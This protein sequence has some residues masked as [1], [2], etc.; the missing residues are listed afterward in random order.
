MRRMLPLGSRR[1][2]SAEAVGP[3]ERYMALVGSKALIYD[4]HQYR[5][6]QKLDSFRHD[7]LQKPLTYMDRRLPQKQDQGFFSSWFTQSPPPAPMP[8]RKGFYLYGSPGTGKT[9]L[10]DTL[11]ETLDI[12]KKKRVHFNSFML[13][14]HE[15]LHL[16]NDAGGDALV[17]VARELSKEALLICFDEFQVTDIADAMILKRLFTCLF[18]H[19]VVVVATSNRAPDELYKNGIQR[20]LFLPF[21]DLLKQQ[22]DVVNL[23][24][25]IDYRS[26]GTHL[27]ETFF[28]PIEDKTEALFDESFLIVCQ[29]NPAAPLTVPIIQGRT[30]SVDLASN[31]AALLSFNHICRKNLGAADYMSLCNAFHT[32]FLRDIP[33]MD[34]NDRNEL[35]RFITFI[36]EVYDKRV[37]LVCLAETSIQDMFVADANEIAYDEVFAWDRCKSRLI[38]MQ[39]KQYREKAEK[40][41]QQ[42]VNVH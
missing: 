12:E 27:T 5:V 3:L 21:I 22:C 39:S 31:G 9:F 38:E 6:L 30:L 1:C 20:D 13:N 37:R 41:V 40:A 36:D 42:R 25:G 35:R 34:I 7:I 32:I 14:V 16:M 28:Y 8:T 19:G 2:F 18:E 23:D 15:R 26:T 33:Q 4:E 17:P 24:A 11:F 29:G 10:M